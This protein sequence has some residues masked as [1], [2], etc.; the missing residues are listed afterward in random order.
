LKSSD[1]IA[2]IAILALLFTSGVLAAN[3][4]VLGSW[5]VGASL[6]LA[7]IFNVKVTLGPTPLYVGVRGFEGAFK[8]GGLIGSAV[9][10]VISANKTTMLDNI[11]MTDTYTAG[12][13][14]LAAGTEIYLHVHDNNP[15]WDFY[16]EWYHAIVGEN[17]PV[18]RLRPGFGTRDAPAPLGEFS[19]EYYGKMVRYITGSDQYWQITPTFYLTKRNEVNDLGDFWKFNLLNP[20]GAVIR[21]A[22]AVSSASGAPDSAA[23]DFSLSGTFS[24]KLSVDLGV[25]WWAYGD[26]MISLGPPPD[27]GW[28]IGYLVIWVSFNSTGIRA[29][30]LTANGWTLVNQSPNLTPGYLN[31][32]KVLPPVSGN[33][34]IT[35]S[36]TY[37][38]PI[39][40]GSIPRGTGVS[41]RIWIADLQLPADAARGVSD[42]VP[43][44]YGAVGG[45]GITQTIFA[46]GFLISSNRP[47]GQLIWAAFKT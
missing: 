37:E 35:G 22:T 43:P 5:L 24:L 39:D 11:L 31:F 45:Y 27:Y 1:R 14:Q 36:A 47:T 40:T 21:N 8:P 20:G 30:Y 13:V 16:D 26:P 38:I 10:E 44:P 17:Q 18:M 12:K 42:G 34:I 2:R 29:S 4:G 15:Q 33:G 23:A 46:N 19:E 6:T 9:V 3:Q 32:Y 41:V 28:R 25:S 7:P